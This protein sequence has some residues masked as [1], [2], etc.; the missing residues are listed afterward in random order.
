MAT[1]ADVEQLF[2]SLR[3]R[4]A[5]IRGRDVGLRTGGQLG[6]LLKAAIAMRDVELVTREVLAAASVRN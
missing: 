1:E 4:M 6:C 3:P 5:E 2:E